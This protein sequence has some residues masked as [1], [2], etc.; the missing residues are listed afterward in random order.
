MPLEKDSAKPAG[1]HVAN[2]ALV[3]ARDED[4]GPAAIVARRDRDANPSNGRKKRR[5]C[6]ASKQWHPALLEVSAP[7]SYSCP[8]QNF[9]SSA[10]F[11]R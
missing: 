5:H 1:I 10:S 4:R 8:S 9:T 11:S 6:W 7:D 2:E 3:S